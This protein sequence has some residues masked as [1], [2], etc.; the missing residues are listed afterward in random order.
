MLSLVSSWKKLFRRAEPP[1]G[2]PLPF[3]NRTGLH[4][5]AKLAS[6]TIQRN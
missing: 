6:A 4:T 1:A 2:A 5:A 3:G